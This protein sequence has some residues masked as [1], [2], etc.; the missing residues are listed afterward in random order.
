MKINKIL[1][2]G[3]GPVGCTVAEALSTN[4]VNITILDKRKHIAGNCY[5]YKNKQ[6][7]L[8]QKYGPHYFR[9][10]NKNK[11]K[12]LSNFTK[13]IKGDY[14]VKS[15]YKKKYFFLWAPGRVHLH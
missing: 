5:D 10:E 15:S 2:V 3:A 1:I 13:W 9:T 6:G 8:V 12:Y 14:F 7:I 4:K 11:I